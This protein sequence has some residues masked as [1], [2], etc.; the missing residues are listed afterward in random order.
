MS[1]YDLLKNRMAYRG[2]TP[3]KRLDRDKDASLKA[4]LISAYQSEVIEIANGGLFRALINPDKLTEDIDCKI[5]SVPYRDVCLNYSSMQ[6]K[7]TIIKE[8][9][10]DIDIKEGD[11]VTWMRTRTHWLVYLQYIEESAYFRS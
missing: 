6:D 11:V 9:I 3:Q 7:Y 5:L 1:G 4:A 10:E 8:R 2:T